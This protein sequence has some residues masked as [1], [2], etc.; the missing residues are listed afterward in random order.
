MDPLDA[1]TADKF[2][3]LPVRADITVNPLTATDSPSAVAR[4]NMET[5]VAQFYVDLSFSFTLFDARLGQDETHQH[6]ALTN[7]VKWGERASLANDLNDQIRLD[8]VISRTLGTFSRLFCQ[9]PMFQTCM[10]EWAAMVKSVIS[11]YI[12]IDGVRP[13]NRKTEMPSCLWAAVAAMPQNLGSRI[14]PIQ[15]GYLLTEGILSARKTDLA[16]D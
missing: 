7:V 2:P 8:I 15:S 4:P 6:T 9:D 14:T 5:M 13:P 11:L 10:W 1:A 3:D 12:L 16:P